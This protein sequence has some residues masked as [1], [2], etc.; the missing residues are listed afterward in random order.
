[1]STLVYYNVNFHMQ[2]IASFRRKDLAEAYASFE[3][4]KRDEYLQRQKPMLTS[5]EY[6]G[7]KTSVD[8]AVTV[9][10]VRIEFSDDCLETL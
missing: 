8:R 9:N 1:M 6:R 5:G 7:L 4:K 2:K 10:E 3:R